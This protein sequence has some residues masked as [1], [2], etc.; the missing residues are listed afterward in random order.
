MGAHEVHL[1]A[2]LEHQADRV[3]ATLA[4]HR[5]PGRVLGGTVGPRVIRF[6]LQLAPTTR[7][8]QVQALSDDLALAL[9]VEALRIGLEAG[10]VVLEFPRPDPGTVLLRE[11]LDQVEPLPIA[12]CVLGVTE[13]GTPLLARLSS[14]DVAHIL[15]AGTTGSGKSVLLRALVASLWGRGVGLVLVDPKRRTFLPFQGGPLLLP[16]VSE[17]AEMVG[18]LRRL[19][20]LMEERDQ[21][22]ENGPRVVLVIDELSDL[23]MTGDGMEGQLIRLLQRGREAGLHVIAATQRPSAAVVSGLMKANFPLRLVGR[24][25]AAEEARIAAGQRETGAERLL[26]RGDFL[27]VSGARVVRFQAAV[28]DEAQLTD[29]ARRPSGLTLPRLPEAALEPEPEPALPARVAEA[30]ARLRPEWERLGPAYRRGERG[31]LAEAIRIAFP[32]APNGGAFIGWTKAALEIL[33]GEKTTT[34]GQILG[35]GA[36][37]A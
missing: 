2:Y 21:R 18:V 15:I 25:T 31:V 27:A 37:A 12:T 6:R 24:V 7:L 5:A 14:P 20:Q 9:K 13:I 26:G 22:G 28:A 34:T 3:E 1:K 35:S 19:V 30:V 36:L 10:L 4:A 29:L 11:V 23:L 8:A 17:P 32:G 16:P 33:A